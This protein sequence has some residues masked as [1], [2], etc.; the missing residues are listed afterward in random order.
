MRTAEPRT[1]KQRPRS[2][3]ESLE[4]GHAAARTS[5]ASSAPISLLTCSNVF[6]DGVPSCTVWASES[7]RQGQ[8]Q[9]F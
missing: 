6:D 7:A 5:S 4:Q 8:W 2:G 1:N 9:E 3:A